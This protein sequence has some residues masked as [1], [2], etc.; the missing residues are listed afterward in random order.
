MKTK[1]KVPTTEKVSA[2]VNTLF[3]TREAYLQAAAEDMRFH[4]FDAAGYECPPVHV[5]V[6]FPKGSRGKAGAIGQCFP[7]EL[8]EGKLHHLYIS[9]VLGQ[10][11]GQMWADV[12]AHELVHATVGCDKGHKAAFK[13]CA[14][15]IGLEGK[16]T[17]THGGEAF[18]RYVEGLVDRLGP[19]PHA[20]VKLPKRGS[21]GSRLKLIM[22]P[23]DRKLR[24]SRSVYEEA[25]IICGSCDGRFIMCE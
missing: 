14:E 22:C 13:K 18:M 17:A 8:S 2:P 9:P 23:C 10:D 4:L 16:M 20:K 25:P 12:L 7:P 6:G 15:G 11:G 3:P 5:S 24:V 19:Y 1:A 21:K